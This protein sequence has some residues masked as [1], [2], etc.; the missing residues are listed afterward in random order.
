MLTRNN[1]QMSAELRAS[2]RTIFCLQQGLDHYKEIVDP[3]KSELAKLKDVT[4]QKIKYEQ[5][6]LATLTKF[7]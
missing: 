1:A 3:V 5:K 4:N 7:K 2:G 6:R